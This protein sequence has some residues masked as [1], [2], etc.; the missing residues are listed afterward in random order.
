MSSIGV[1]I[2]I[3]FDTSEGFQ[4]LKTYRDAVKQN[5]KMLILTNPGERIMDPDFG[6][7]IITYL[8]SNFSENIQATLNQKIYS[9]VQTYM[10]SIEITDIT[11]VVLD[12][13]TN[14]V[15]FRIIYAIPDIGFNDLLEFTI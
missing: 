7:G 12:P 1:K 3:A 13:D 8:F 5:L 14:S 9:Q 10:P 15:S 6:V 11:F 4:M 2:P